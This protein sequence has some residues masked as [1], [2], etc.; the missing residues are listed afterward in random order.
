MPAPTPDQVRVV[1]DSSCCHVEPLPPPSC[2]MKTPRV[3]HQQRSQCAGSL[4]QCFTQCAASQLGASYLPADLLSRIL[5]TA[6]AAEGDS[7]AAW[8]RIS[9]VS[10]AWR[11]SVA[12]AWCCPCLA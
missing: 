12:G 2:S 8:L 5:R 6:L 1:H 7:L 10:R 11:D 3:L 9:I 4:S